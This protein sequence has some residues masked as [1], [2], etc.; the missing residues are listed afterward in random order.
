ML[1]GNFSLDSV[2]L[3]LKWFRF[4]ENLPKFSWN[5]CKFSWNCC[6]LAGLIKR[7]R[8][9]ARS[10]LINLSTSAFVVARCAFRRNHKI[11]YSHLSERRGFE[12]AI[13][14]HPDGICVREHPLGIREHP[15]VF[16][17]WISNAYASIRKHPQVSECIC[18]YPNAFLTAM[19]LTAKDLETDLPRITIEVALIIKV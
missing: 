9:K 7:I 14:K 16:K 11:D 12:R 15:W 18:E 1:N 5:C 6:K 2:R 19:D 8:A 13:W 10:R 4:Y 3:V 17:F